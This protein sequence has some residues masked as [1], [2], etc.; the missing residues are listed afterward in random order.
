M[1][2]KEGGAMRNDCVHFEFIGFDPE[3][4]IRNFV[5]TVVENLH[6]SAPSD[7]AMKVAISRGKGV[8]EASCRI[9]SRAGTFVAEVV[10]DSPIRAIQK[11]EE[12]ISMQ[13]D[14]WKRRRFLN[15]SSSPGKEKIIGGD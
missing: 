5:S 7:S 10:S 1:I 8:I 6:L 9:A 14:D 12:N 13:L 4:E 11:I 3:H 2:S 15:E